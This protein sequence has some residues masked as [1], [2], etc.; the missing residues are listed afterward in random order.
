MT[1]NLVSRRSFLRAGSLAGAAI[2]AP[3]IVPSSALGRDGAVAP[4]NRL[5]WAYIGTGNQANN[6]MG[7]VL[8]RD[9]V[10]IVGV[11]DV[12][13][14]Q[15]ERALKQIEKSYGSRDGCESYEDFRE[16]IAR[17][18]IDVVY[19]ATPDHWHVPASI[20]AI[21]AGKDVYCQKPLTL[22][23]GEGRA[24]VEVV[25]RHAAILQTGAQQR[26]MGEFRRACEL[27]INGRL[28]KIN[29]I[30]VGLPRG[31][32]SG[33]QP[34]MPVPPELNYDLWLGPAPWKPYTEARCH[35]NFRQIS[36]YSGGKLIDWGAHH[37]DIVQWALE[38][39]AA[40]PLEVDG[41]GTFPTDGIYDTA[42][43]YDVHFLY[44]NDV[45][46]HA[47]NS[48]PN[49]VKFFGDEGSLFVTRGRIYSD[50]PSLLRSKIGA[51]EKR[52]FVS[53]GAHNG[54]FNNFIECVK[55][56]Q[57]PISTAE[58]GHRSATVNHLANISLR[59]GRKLKWDTAKEQFIGDPEANRM[60]HRAMRSP[61]TL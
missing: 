38:T 28:G 60:I 15:R 58:I 61:W 18:D 6:T 50:P 21:R 32:E 45:R 4:S 19:N 47:S 51:N 57:T 13:A 42:L 59:L 23:I 53:E 16:L 48:F 1:S 3:V 25:K 37:L 14:N 54:H 30:E 20:A 44:P 40:G 24:L 26:S 39:D 17:D 33:P 34:V 56:R 31:R 10:R 27:V 12:D 35:R 11:C 36:D 46:V 41:V 9:D 2:A 22:T 7:L 49:G 43:T 55:T 52:L 8:G 29:R 5:A